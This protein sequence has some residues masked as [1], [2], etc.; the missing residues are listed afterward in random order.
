LIVTIIIV[1]LLFAVGWRRLTIEADV[2]GFLPRG[3]QVV[4]DALQVFQH[5]PI[6]DK[7]VVDIGFSEE[8]PDLL[9]ECGRRVEA[10]LRDSKLFKDVGLKEFQSIVPD[11]AFHAVKE[12]PVLFSAEALHNRVAPLLDFHAVRRQLSAVQSSLLNL[13]GIG[14][15][16][17][18]TRDPLGFKDIVLEQL[19]Q[20][21]PTQSARIY[22]EQILSEDGRH[23]L[24][25][26]DSSVSS[27]DTDFARQVAELMQTITTDLNETYG[28]PEREITLTPM[29]AY[30]IALDNEL[31]A[32]KDVRN[33][34]FFAT[35]GIV[36]LLVFTF[37]RPYLGVLSL[38]PAIAGAAA[39]F[40]VYSLI[41]E[42]I[43]LMVLGFGGAIIS[44]SVD[45][46]IAYLLFLDRPHRT[47]GKEASREVR[48]VGLVAALTTIGA[49]SSLVVSGFPILEQLGQFTA[50][51]IAFSFIFVHT[52]FP[53]IFSEMQAARTRR[54]P[55]H[56]LVDRLSR[57]GSKGLVI[58]LVFGA[59][60]LFFVKPDFNV[61]LDSMNTVSAETKAA[62]ATLTRVWGSVFHKV[63]VMTQ[64]E[65]LKDLQNKGDRLAAM[66][67]REQQ[68]GTLSAGLVASM[69]FPGEQ[70]QKNNFVAW[71]AFWS[72][73][74][75]SALENNI[76]NVS[77]ELGFA[78]DAFNPF[79][80][81]LAAKT[82]PA[83]PTAIPKD[84]F[85]I[86]G[87][88][89]DPETKTW[90]QVSGLTTGNDY[91][92]EA[93]IKKYGRLG[94]FFD[95]ELFS[96][97]LG[98]LLF[99]TFTKMLAI[100]GLSVFILL[101]FYFVD[102]PLTLIALLPV[103][104][105]LVSTLGCLKL[106][107]R[108][109]DIPSLMLAIIIVGMGVDYTLFLVRSHQRYDDADH[110]HHGLIRMTVFLAG[111]ST[112]IGF[113]VLSTAQH[114]LLR[115]AGL[116]LLLGIGFSLIGAFVILPPLLTALKRRRMEKPVSGNIRKRVAQR[117]C[118]LEAYP[119]L[120]ARF[121]MR[122]DPMF[123][124]LPGLLDA[125]EGAQTIMD[126]GC[127]YGIQTAWMLERFPE[128]RVVAIDP[129]ADRI[130]VAA[131]VAG[132]RARI[133]AGAAPDIP[134][135]S[136]PADLVVMLDIA[137]YLDETALN[138]TLRRLHDCLKN[139]GCLIIRVTV[140][141]Q[142]RFPVLYWIEELRLRL[143]RMPS[144][145]RTVDTLNAM[146]VETGFKVEQT[147]VSGGQGELCWL[148][149]VKPSP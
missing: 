7:L 63:Y 45:H 54:M 53:R 27:T 32:R 117:Y 40:C 71:K 6:Q 111:A 9:V 107:G 76:R 28:G 51:G 149:A 89:Q 132:T 13:S 77:A 52:I 16:A 144:F 42:T 102:I 68:A 56:G 18:I 2:V 62:E 142:R 100:I 122:F 128:A 97:R 41:H 39:A 106:L 78:R 137:H 85:R 10:F 59:A 84:Y 119:R 72:L 8:N 30:R 24:V 139:N 113:G 61:G 86:L 70:G 50:L 49:F 110:P 69:L 146:L 129:D 33:A 131:R 82:P 81:M 135:L 37:P 57:T 47:F 105:A 25:T 19:A 38:L 120:F 136:D 15:S 74:R 101:L 88:G 134:A 126:I 65:T 124:E 43:S 145:Y 93:F 31:I 34:I 14:Q 60:M 67:A 75:R 66:I 112:I 127:G 44:I 29:G 12:M 148:I 46:G 55:L 26:A 83:E 20:L 80:E 90:R 108:P 23:L 140:P 73:E 99:A 123:A 64:G 79:F 95:P 143:T 114:S 1:G 133:S 116:S 138:Q 17:F 36:L 91:H 4:A 104:F 21:A 121:K 92:A 5:H 141:P 103:M 11:L 96:E 98:Q 118:M 125:S 58:V 35:L 22:K 3:D 115:S 87:I 48:A 94:T 147:A 109:L 130:R